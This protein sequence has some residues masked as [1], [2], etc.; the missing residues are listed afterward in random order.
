MIWYLV[1]VKV[2]F[3]L[4]VSV[5]TVNEYGN[6]LSWQSEP[7][8]PRSPSSGSAIA[9]AVNGC[10][11]AREIEA[12]GIGSAAATSGNFFEDLTSSE[13]YKS[14]KVASNPKKTM[15]FLFQFFTC[16]IQPSSR[17]SSFI[18]LLMNHVIKFF[19]WMHSFTLR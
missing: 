13:L 14:T 12:L 3:F 8:S 18:V 16:C 1:I 4:Y 9:A 2:H 10:N 15:L 6:W 5:F 11:A 19:I 7:P 17:E